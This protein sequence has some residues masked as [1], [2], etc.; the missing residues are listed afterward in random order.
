MVDAVAKI[1][2]NPESEPPPRVRRLPDDFQLMDEVSRLR[3]ELGDFYARL[4]GEELFDA[5]VKA[6]RISL[7]PLE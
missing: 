1:A 3:I 7:R 6:A 2:D 4:A 5:P